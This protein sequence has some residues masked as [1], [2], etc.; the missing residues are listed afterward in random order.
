MGYVEIAEYIILTIEGQLLVWE[1]NILLSLDHADILWSLWKDQ[2]GI[3][4]IQTNLTQLEGLRL[5][6]RE[7]A[8]SWAISLKKFA[9]VQS[10]MFLI[11]DQSSSSAWSEVTKDGLLLPPLLLSSCSTLKLYFH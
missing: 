10:S 1:S 3:D 2:N 6:E 8:L 9:R 5:K 7:E 11:V 4:F